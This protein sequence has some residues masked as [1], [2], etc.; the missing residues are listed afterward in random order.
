[1]LLLEIISVLICFSAYIGVAS[2]FK[3]WLFKIIPEIEV[4]RDEKLNDSEKN[5][6]RI[7]AVIWPI[8]IPFMLI[9][10]AIMSIKD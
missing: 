9:C 8:S 3:R 5:L 2:F 6:F 10:G 1:M 4:S 7:L